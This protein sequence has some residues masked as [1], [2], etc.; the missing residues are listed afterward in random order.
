MKFADLETI[1]M[2]YPEWDGLHISIYTDGS[3][4]DKN[5]NAGEGIYCKLFIFYLTTCHHLTTHFSHPYINRAPRV[6]RH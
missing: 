6:G 2:L 3:L 4:R 5:G 1:H